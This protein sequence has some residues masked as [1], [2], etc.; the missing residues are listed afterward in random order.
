[1][2]G[3]FSLGNDKPFDIFHNNTIEIIDRNINGLCKKGDIL[4]SIKWLDLIGIVD[5]EKE[6]LIWSWGPGNLSRQHH[7][8]LLEKGN[9]LIFD[10]GIKRYYSRIVELDPLTKGIV[11]EYKAN[12][13][14]KFYSS[15]RG[16]SQ[17]LPN[18]NTLIT[19]SNKGRVFEI[20]RDGRT[21]WE[22]Y[23]PEIRTK[24]R[25]RS[26]IYRM[27][28]ITDPENSPFIRGPK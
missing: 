23:N 18:G 15:G 20:T 6:E 13:P 11:W 19:E 1:M 3:R 25:Q 28:R 4:I 16:S 14:Y 8:T 17:R 26:A 12:S 7:P 27:M 10:N 2:E 21:V 22:F 5:V 24:K 9:I